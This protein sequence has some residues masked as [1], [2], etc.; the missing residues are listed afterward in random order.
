[1]SL[2]FL[3]IGFRY[4]CMHMCMYVQRHLRTRNLAICSAYITI[5]ITSL[6]CFLSMA[7]FSGLLGNTATPRHHIYMFRRQA[8]NLVRGR[9]SWFWRWLGLRVWGVSGSPTGPS[10]IMVYTFRVLGGLSIYHNDT[11]TLWDL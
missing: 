1:M 7:G 2:C 9:P 8:L 11:W 3:D 10:I 5:L 4:V 6:L